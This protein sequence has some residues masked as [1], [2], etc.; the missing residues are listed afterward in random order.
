MRAQLLALREDDP[1]RVAVGREDLS[2]VVD[3]HPGKSGYGVGQLGPA[4]GPGVLV[5]DEA[6]YQRQSHG[7]SHYQP[8][9]EPH[10]LSLLRLH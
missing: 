4:V 9:K 5:L 3:C 10:F 1:G 7:E 2:G 8:H 6:H